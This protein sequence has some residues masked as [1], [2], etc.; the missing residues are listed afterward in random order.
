[1]GFWA[2]KKATLREWLRIFFCQKVFICYFLVFLFTQN[3][4]NMSTMILDVDPEQEKA[5]EGLL[6]CMDISF[7]TITPKNDFWDELSEH[8]K[9]RIQ[10]GLDDA[11]AGRYSSLKSVVE[12]LINQ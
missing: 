12:K 5:L 6:S 4:F 1:V 3:S 7:Q 2:T 11:Q 8:T 10:K 9:N